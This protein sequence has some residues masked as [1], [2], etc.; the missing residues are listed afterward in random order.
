MTDILQQLKVG[1]IVLHFELNHKKILS[2]TWVTFQISILLQLFLFSIVVGHN[3]T[4]LQTEK[5]QIQKDQNIKLE[6]KV[7]ERTTELVRANES[8]HKQKT[9]LADLNNI[10]DK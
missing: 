4:R 7:S 1:I 9:E 2:L 5:L 6:R 10:K 8:I 3:I